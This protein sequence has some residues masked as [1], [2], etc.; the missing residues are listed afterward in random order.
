[1][2]MN[3]LSPTRMNDAVA[4]DYLFETIQR[5][6]RLG[7]YINALDAQFYSAE[8]TIIKD[9]ALFL[10]SYEQG[11][12]KLIE[13]LLTILTA[14]FYPEN[15]NYQALVDELLFINVA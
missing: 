12:S 1:M 3:R 9:K 6:S 10:T 11:L 8:K 4:H 15:K 7:L 14:Y 2:T 13:S 5:I